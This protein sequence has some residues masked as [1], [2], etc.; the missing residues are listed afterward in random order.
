VYTTSPGKR[1]VTRFSRFVSAVDI[2][3]WCL[4]G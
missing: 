1:L 4:V 3:A 2:V